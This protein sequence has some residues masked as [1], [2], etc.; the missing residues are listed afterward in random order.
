MVKN[1]RLAKSISDASWS[2]FINYLN[3]KA[4][5]HYKLTEAVDSKGTSQTCLCGNPVPK[6]LKDR[7]HNCPACCVIEDRDTHSAKVILSRSKYTK[8]T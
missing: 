6:T 5:M 7:V 2:T 3:Y 8:T 4:K 1:H